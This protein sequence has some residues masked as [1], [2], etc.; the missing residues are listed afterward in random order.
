MDSSGLFVA[1][2]LHPKKENT[3]AKSEGVTPKDRLLYIGRR[4]AEVMRLRSQLTNA[5]EHVK[6]VKAELSQAIEALLT[7]AEQPSLPFGKGGQ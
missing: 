3:V 7:E 2:A 4:R 6:E 1:G 5:K